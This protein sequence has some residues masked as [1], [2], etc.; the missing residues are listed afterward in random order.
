MRTR[1]GF[2]L[3]ELLVVI[4]IIAILIGLLLPAVQ[5]VRESAGRA[6]CTNNLKQIALGMHNF[7]SAKKYFP[8]L[9]GDA[10]G[11]IGQDFAFSPL[12]S[13]LPYI[14]QAGLQNLI[15]FTK[16]AV[17]GPQFFRGIINPAHDAAAG[18]KVSLF[19]CPSDGRPPEFTQT[20]SPNYR[21][22]G[23]TAT[24]VTAGTNY[25]FNM[26]TGASGS[27]PT[28][29]AFYDSQFPTDGV[30]WY[31][32]KNGFA[33][34]SD[35]SSNTL[36]VS[37]SLLGPGGANVTSATPPSAAPTRHYVGLNTSAFL[38]GGAPAGGWRVGSSTGPLVTGRPGA[39][40]DS[41]SRAWTGNRGSTWF[42]G[43]RDWNVVFNT[44][45]LPNDPLPDCG[46]HGR[47]FF[48]ARS[49]HSG[50]VNAAMAD[51][52][53]KFVRNAVDPAVWNAAATRAGGEAN[54]EL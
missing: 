3:I 12:A 6:K 30:F 4:A 20:D 33:A 42:W 22:F 47:G 28:E 50:G 13:T 45:L 18:T 40:C 17:L 39:A 27:S 23:A 11:S 15:D 37:E 25:V 19:L 14:E 54:G 52:S 2:T 21:G 41:G 51:G 7:E 38:A 44:A 43:G 36:L 29:F 48:G 53:V 24:F 34:I 9:G 35:G 46:A 5:K 16:P 10:T 8:G 31:G 49:M 1:R 26:G 32:A